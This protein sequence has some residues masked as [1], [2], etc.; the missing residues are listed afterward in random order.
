MSIP[1]ILALLLAIQTIPQP[2]GFDIFIQFR[3]TE[4]PRSGAICEAPLDLG[5]EAVVQT[6]GNV[7]VRALPTTRSERVGGIRNGD[8]V[9][10]WPPIRSTETIS[11]SNLWYPVQAEDSSWYGYVAG[12]LIG[13]PQFTWGC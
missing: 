5:F 7:N 10:I 4:A 12:S 6:Q 1:T 8:T 11:G 2:G 13:Q 3:L 9:T